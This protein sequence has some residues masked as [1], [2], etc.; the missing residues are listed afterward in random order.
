[1]QALYRRPKAELLLPFITVFILTLTAICFHPKLLKPVSA[2]P[3]YQELTVYVAQTQSACEPY[4]PNCLF[5]NAEGEALTRALEANGYQ[6]ILI[7]GSY[8]VTQ[9]PVQLN[10][11]VTLGSQSNG[12]ITTE[13]TDC[14]KPLF[15]I[16]SGVSIVDLKINAGMACSNPGRVM[17]RINS[18]SPVTVQ[19]NTL[20]GGSHVFE[21]LDNMGSL[22]IAAN[23]ISGFE[24]MA[25][26]RAGENPLGMLRLVAN[27][28]LG[29][30]TAQPVVNC[31]GNGNVDHNFW[32]LNK[33]PSQMTTNCNAQDPKRL[34]AEVAKDPAGVK[35]KEI[36]INNT[37]AD[38]NAPISLQTDTGSIHAY[39]VDHGF[40][41]APAFPEISASIGTVCSNTYD[42]FITSIN[43]ANFLDINLKLSDTCVALM[44]GPLKNLNY[45]EGNPQ[46]VPL[47]WLDPSQTFT[48]GWDRI[49]EVEFVP[50][51]QAPFS[52]CDAS[53]RNVSVRIDNNPV[54][55]P[56]LADLAYTPFVLA[57]AES[58]VL[59]FALSF[60]NE[61]V[62]VTWTAM[63]ED[64]ISGYYVLRS[65]SAEGTYAR[66]S[67]L[68]TAS[69]ATNG[70]YLFREPALLPYGLTYWYK[71]ELMSK[72]GQTIMTTLPL[73]I[74]VGS[75]AQTSTQ[76]YPIGPTLISPG[77][78]SYPFMPS[79]PAAN[80]SL[81]Q[82]AFYQ[83]YPQTAEPEAT[84]YPL[85]LTPM[86]NE[87]ETIALT[88]TPISLPSLIPISTLTPTIVY[89]STPMADS[90]VL[91][92]YQFK[93]LRFWWALPAGAT[94]AL[95]L[96]LLSGAFVSHKKH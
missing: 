96:F 51:A 40:L 37:S 10:R 12:S 57:L 93:Q 19:H 68:L 7:V 11:P 88:P 34:G 43:H 55:H 82:T 56:G 81:T 85:Q 24:N 26:Q 76:T 45:C 13:N 8:K 20:E 92:P 61:R 5:D 33:L 80:L 47:R 25:V 70:V 44:N 49:G 72:D 63:K 36:T 14:S 84:V 64:A 65:D 32:G 39:L 22:T 9:I 4:M 16:S 67:N 62:N 2:M 77:V 46:K 27:N 31:S 60:G 29:N 17:F 75:E 50:G 28:I 74:H 87:I 30:N 91:E 79:T 42:L 90:K 59:N 54:V 48:R 95:L 15:E 94:V 73:H 1:M 35:A 3:D 38:L 66:I 23:H 71:L 21:Y 69:Q 89:R 83:L 18:T 6:K 58:E 41:S 86:A 52:A 53:R 78:T